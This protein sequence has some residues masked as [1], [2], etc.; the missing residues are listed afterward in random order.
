MSK[1]K[2]LERENFT[3]PPRFKQFVKCLEEVLIFKE[4]NDEEYV[5]NLKQMR[6]SIREKERTISLS[7]EHLLSSFETLEWRV[8]Q[9]LLDDIEE[10][11]NELKGLK[12]K[13]VDVKT[14]WG[15]YD[16]PKDVKSK[17]N[18]QLIEFLKFL[19]FEC[20]VLEV[21]FPQSDIQIISSKL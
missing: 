17:K 18:S 7:L 9:H 15:E 13:L 1:I 14:K 8:K 4:S 3:V 10:H 16:Y 2:E 12:R 21:N 5:R 6:I 11:G 20:E 19:G